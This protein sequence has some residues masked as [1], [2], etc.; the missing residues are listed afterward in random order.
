MKITVRQ[1]KARKKKKSLDRFENLLCG[2]VGSEFNKY[3][4]VGDYLIVQGTLRFKRQLVKKRYQKNT[5]LNVKKI[6]PFLLNETEKKLS[7]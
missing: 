3:Y 5:Q 7:L 2:T 6:Y 1:A 4:K